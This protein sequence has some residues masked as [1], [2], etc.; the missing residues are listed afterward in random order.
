MDKVKE[1]NKKKCYFLNTKIS[2]QNYGCCN[3]FRGF[4]YNKFFSS[5]V[6]YCNSTSLC[7]TIML[8]F[9]TFNF[10]F[11]IFLVSLQYVILSS[12]HSTTYRICFWT[13][14]LYKIQI[15]ISI[16]PAYIHANIGKRNPGAL[17]HQVPTS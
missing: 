1:K 5:T 17:H 13:N 4:F 6:L 3:F 7:F 9:V 16:T 2:I 8:L 15:H 10:L 12:G 11:L 14:V